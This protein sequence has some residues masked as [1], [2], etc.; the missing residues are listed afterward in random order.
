[1]K[2]LSKVLSY[3]LNGIEGYLVTTEVDISNGL[4]TFDIVGLGDMAVRESRERVKSS[5]KNSGF[6]SPMNKV[7]VNLAPADTR[8]EGP[9]F[10][11]SIALGVLSASN[12]I[13]YEKVKDYICIG[14]LSLGGRG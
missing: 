14:E 9:L 10:D 3:G 11:L 5:I 13:S 2:M 8:K 12:Q 7:I 4:P 6:E 1:M